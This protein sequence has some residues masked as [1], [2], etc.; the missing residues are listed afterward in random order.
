MGLMLAEWTAPLDAEHLRPKEI[1]EE[2]ERGVTLACDLDLKPK[3]KTTSSRRP[4]PWWNQEIAEVRAACVRS[5]R[6]FTRARRRGQ[7]EAEAVL[8]KEA[9]K[10]LNSAIRRHKK[11]CWA[12]L[13][14][15]VDGDPWG[16]PYKIVM[17]RLQGPPAPNRMEPDTLS[18]V[19]DGLFPEH[20]PLIRG[21]PFG[22]VEVQNFS[23]EEVTA[24][25][26]KFKARNKAPG[27]D[28]YCPK[29]GARPFYQTV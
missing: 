1:A 16:K 10:T 22:D 17:R 12:D 23:A 24:V 28:N 26:N 13:V 21:N 3:P 2:L 5:R 19:V 18:E 11:K 15:S 4:V 29:N 6:A 8:Y 25:V 20:P 9:R 14:K 7:G 27:P